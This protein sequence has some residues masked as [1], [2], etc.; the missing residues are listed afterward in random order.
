MSHSLKVVDVRA[1]YGGLDI[2]RGI[3]LH[4]DAGE[5]VA[6][7]GPNGSG[8]STLLK[9][10]FGLVTVTD[11]SV[12]FGDAEITN[13]P[14][15]QHVATGLA[16]IPQTDNVF[17]Q[18]T[19]EENLEM[20]GYIREDGVAERKEYV[21]GLFPDLAKRRRT[22]HAGQLSGGQ[23]QMLA[24][25]RALMVEPSTLLLDEPSAGLSP[26]MA[27]VLFDR[28]LE[29]NRAGVAILLVEQNAR[30]ALKMAARGYVL[31]AGQTRLEGAG[32]ELLDDDEVGRLYLGAGAIR[33]S[34]KP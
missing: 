17:P 1:G 20:G 32:R 2:C 8:K 24:V 15:E 21:Y 28:I 31:A 14:P 18:L 19:I 34:S 3:S 5:I 33:E 23:R 9:A 6:I 26:K 29:I 30:Q 12:W 16:Y 7:I 4:V 22:A 25:G 11:G 13:R 27:T 10:I